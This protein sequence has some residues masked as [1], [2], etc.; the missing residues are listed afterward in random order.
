MPVDP[1]VVDWFASSNQPLVELMQ[2]V[3]SAILAVDERITESI[4]WKSTT[5]SYRG[6]IASIDPKAKRHVSLL[7]HQG[8]AIPGQHPDFE[9]G[10]STARY[11]RFAD[12][13]E[14]KAKRRG[15][16]AAVRAWVA[17]KDRA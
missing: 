8:A 17:M 4:K 9:G 13:A 3:R 14:V 11:M 15:L 10:G 1:E 7:F 16:Q 6:N 5:F 2:N 12:R